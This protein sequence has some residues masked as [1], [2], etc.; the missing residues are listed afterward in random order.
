MGVKKD[1]RLFYPKEEALRRM[2]EQKT[3]SDMMKMMVM[4]A[5]ELS[6]DE[7]PNAHKPFS[8]ENGSP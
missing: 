6:K 8:G 7:P 2:R 1:T 5:E 3:Q 4:M